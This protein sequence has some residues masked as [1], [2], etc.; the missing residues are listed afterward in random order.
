[1]NM[2][3]RLHIDL[4]NVCSPLEIVEVRKLGPSKYPQITGRWLRH[5]RKWAPNLLEAPQGFKR[6]AISYPV[7]LYQD[8][9]YDVGEKSLLVAFADDARRLMLPICVFLQYVDSR[10]WDVVVLKRSLRSH[11]RGLDR[12]PMDFHGVIDYVEA[13]VRPAQYRRVITLGTSRGGFAAI[14]AAMLMR[15][16]RGISICGCPPRR[17]PTSLKDRPAAPD[18]DLCYVFGSDQDRKAALS[19]QELFGGRLRPVPD[20]DDH[21]VLYHMLMR[22]QFGEFLNEMLA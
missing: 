8:P 17:L 10:R 2:F 19:L 16:S 4:E 3:N 11:T 7:M 9:A 22:R 1:V 6:R 20:I 13:E 12:M 15:A 14:W 18:V 5:F 21:V